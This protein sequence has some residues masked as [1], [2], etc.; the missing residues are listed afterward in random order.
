MEKRNVVEE[1]RTPPSEFICSDEHWDKQ[2][3]NVFSLKPKQEKPE[4]LTNAAKSES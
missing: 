4:K 1:G 3:A 2:A